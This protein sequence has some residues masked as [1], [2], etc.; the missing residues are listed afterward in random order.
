MDY[1]DDAILPMHAKQFELAVKGTKLTKKNIVCARKVLVDQKTRAEVCEEEN[2]NKQR[3]GQIITVVINN[4]KKQ[5][6]ENGLHVIELVVDD[7]QKLKNETEEDTLL[8][9]LLKE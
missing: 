7:K 2:L 9:R 8:T 1:L 4:F 3:L 5:L 6:D